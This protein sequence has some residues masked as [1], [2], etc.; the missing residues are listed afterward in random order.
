MNEKATSCV[1]IDTIRHLFTFAKYFFF[2][3]IIPVNFFKG[4]N[5]INANKIAIF[6]FQFRT[7][8]TV[9]LP[10]Y[11]CCIRICTYLREC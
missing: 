10:T 1:L 7:Q 5:P 11:V 3:R 8:R 4:G 9:Y 2:C 6:S